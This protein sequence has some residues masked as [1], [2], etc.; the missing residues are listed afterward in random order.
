MTTHEELNI[1][2]ERVSELSS[3]EELMA[4]LK[5]VPDDIKKKLSRR[6][7]EAMRESLEHGS[8]IVNSAVQF[9]VSRSEMVGVHSALVILMAARLFEQNRQEVLNGHGGIPVQAAKWLDEQLDELM[10]D[11]SFRMQRCD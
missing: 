1:L 11:D 4:L 8:N 5:D 9:V 7:D 2:L 3:P 10:T 6:G